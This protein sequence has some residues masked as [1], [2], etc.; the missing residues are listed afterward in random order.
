M[1]RADPSAHIGAP[2]ALTTQ[3]A[4]GAAVR[5]AAS[6]NNAVLRADGADIRFVDAHWYPFDA[7][8][9]LSDRQ[10]LDSI[11]QIPATARTIRSTLKRHD[12]DA[13][14]VIGETNI[15]NQATTLDFEPVSALF[16]AA[17]SLEWISQGAQSV[18]WWD[19]HNF[20]SPAGGDYGLL[21]SGPPETEP[22]DAPLPPY[23]GEEL[24][25]M[26][27]AAGS[28]LRA[29][30]TGKSDL[31][32]FQS[33]RNGLRR[34]LLVTTD[35]TRPVTI[36]PSWFKPGSQIDTATYSHTTATTAAPIVHV[37]VSGTS[38]LSLPGQSIVV[39]SGAPAPI[40]HP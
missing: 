8:S 31:L 29:L 15:S 6:W 14:I 7:T 1:T 24:A 9:H 3:Q 12:S 2:W 5:D 38:P 19:M 20:G 18:D 39:L 23:Y 16:A 36:N 28:H 32:G 17:D 10:I 4:A 11:R 30:A 33:D 35:A 37:T 13:A 40:S 25:S 21:S 27:T 26:L 34:V 22:A